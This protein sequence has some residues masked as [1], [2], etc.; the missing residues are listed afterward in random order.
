MSHVL[1][2][3]PISFYW[4]IIRQVVLWV[5]RRLLVQLLLSSLHVCRELS[6][7]LQFQ[8][9]Y[10]LS[11][12]SRIG[13]SYP[14]LGALI[15]LG[16][17]PKRKYLR[18]CWGSYELQWLRIRFPSS[19]SLPSQR[20]VARDMSRIGT[21]LGSRPRARC[22]NWIPSSSFRLPRRQWRWAAARH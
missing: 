1:P 13:F 2:K 12:G 11:R 19:Y 7:R 17:T 22:A 9:Q 4:Y 5:R 21:R 16:P 14:I 10:H 3:L 8:R 15:C 18:G 20:R 6:L